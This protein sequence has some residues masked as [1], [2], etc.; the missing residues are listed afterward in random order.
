MEFLNDS[1]WICQF[2][3]S[4]AVEGES[5]YNEI[6]R[7]G[8]NRLLFCTMIY[9]PYRMLMPRYPQKAIYS[10]E[11]GKYFYLPQSRRYSDLAAQ[12]TTSTDFDGRDLLAEAVHGARKAGISPGAWVT[13][14]AS[15]LLAKSCPS[16][17]IQNLYGSADRLFLCVNNPQVREY[18]LRVCTEIAERYEI[19][20][21]MLDKIPQHC[22]EPDCLAGARLDPVMRT[23]AT[24]CFCP[25]CAAAAA[26]DGIDLQDC[27]QKA[28]ALCSQFLKMPQHVLNSRGHELLGDT[29]VPLLLMEHPWVMDLLHFRIEAIRRFL[30]EMR[31]RLNE[32]RR[33]VKFSVAFVPPITSGHDAAQPRSWLAAQSYA[34]Y[35][36]ADADIIHSV[37]HQDPPAVEYDT[38]R[39][40]DAVAD[41][42]TQIVTHVRACG[43]TEPDRLVD[44]TAAV[45][46]GG[47]QGIGYF[48]YDLMSNEMLRALARTAEN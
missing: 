25:H 5:C 26:G 34:A 2:P 31:S 1:R 29:G 39:A 11:E 21:I 15:G 37:I 36:D 16:W 17:A 10:M 20:E 22:I 42:S 13:T 14:F 41:G 30:A 38:R 19:D 3:A 46:R 45:K 28:L 44:L 9:A 40:V 32:V 35:K 43:P 12:P 24:I 33:G 48:C 7:L 4:L 6:S 18:T 47:A 27:R 23:L 8:T